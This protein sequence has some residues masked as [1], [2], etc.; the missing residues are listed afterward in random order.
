[1]KLIVCT[2]C[3]D[4]VALKVGIM[5]ECFCGASSGAY[6]KSRPGHAKIKGPC[7]PI[8]FANP[9]FIAALKDH[10]QDGTGIDFTAFVLRKDCSS[11][12]HE[13]E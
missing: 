11:V 13:E 8:G 2:T 4:V 12:T 5:R 10:V 6:S 7:I 1:M 3:S 9:S